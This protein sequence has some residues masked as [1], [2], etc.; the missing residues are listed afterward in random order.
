MQ[1]IAGHRQTLYKAAMRR[2]RDHAAA[3]DLVQDT[4]V[5][6]W[7]SAASLQDE[8][9]LLPW[10]LRILHNVWI[11]LCRKP[12]KLLPVAEVPEQAIQIEEPSAWQ[13]VTADDFHKALEQLDEPY[14]SIAIMQYIDNLSNADI[15]QK[16][17]IPYATA[18][19]RLHRARKQL[20]ELLS[21]ILHSDEVS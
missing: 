1:L 2:C 16:M 12:A 20:K 4:C 5:R 21:A 6:A 9:K 17:G 11:D 10:L 19:T 15:A 3:D 7:Q 14:R 13:R 8:S 18:A